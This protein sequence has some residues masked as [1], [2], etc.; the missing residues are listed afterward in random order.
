M[1]QTDD[2]CRTDARTMDDGR[3]LIGILLD[4]VS[5]ADIAKKEYTL[6]NYYATEAPGI[7]CGCFD[8]ILCV[9]TLNISS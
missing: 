4:Y 5:G 1:P 9:Y 6:Y 3:I 2:G 7:D 8:H